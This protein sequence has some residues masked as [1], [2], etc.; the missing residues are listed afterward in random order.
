MLPRVIIQMLKDQFCDYEDINVLTPVRTQGMQIIEKICQ[1]AE[2]SDPSGS[3]IHQDVGLLIQNLP[4]LLVACENEWQ[5]KLSFFMIIK[6]I[7]TA[8]GTKSY[9]SKTSLKDQI[10]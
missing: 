4:Q 5:A 10:C 6:G 2:I 8:A 1:I 9:A 7:T 3:K